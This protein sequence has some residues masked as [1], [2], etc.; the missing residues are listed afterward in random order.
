MRNI[1]IFARNQWIS[2]HTYSRHYLHNW[3]ET[4]CEGNTCFIVNVESAVWTSWTTRS[5]SVTYRENL[6]LIKQIYM[7]ERSDDWE[8]DIWKW[9]TVVRC[10]VDTYKKVTLMLHSYWYTER[11]YSVKTAAI[12]DISYLHHTYKWTQIIPYQ[13]NVDHTVLHKHGSRRITWTRI[14]PYHMNTEHT[15]NMNKEHTEKQ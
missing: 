12:P 1:L 15:Y 13:M 10:A 11:C 14:I 2:H 3:T 5:L 4:Q 7:P 8:T 6:V 9:N